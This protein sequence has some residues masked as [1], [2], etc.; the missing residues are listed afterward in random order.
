MPTSAGYALGSPEPSS[1]SPLVSQLPF[2][3]PKRHES[4]LLPPELECCCDSAGPGQGQH[5]RGRAVGLREGLQQEQ[6]P[7]GGPLPLPGA[8]VAADQ[9][10]SGHFTARVEPTRLP[11]SASLQQ[12]PATPDCICHLAGGIF[13]PL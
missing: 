9:R 4:A 8:G 2:S 11:C 6:N 5:V 10:G 7:P 12:L 1:I 3:L 13:F